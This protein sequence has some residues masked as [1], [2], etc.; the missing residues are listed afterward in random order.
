[1]EVVDR[2]IVIKERVR[3]VK[4]VEVPAQPR[5]DEWAG[6][7]IELTRQLDSGRVYDRHLPDIAVAIDEILR[8]LARRN[9]HHGGRMWPG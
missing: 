9:T 4:R 8:S 6:L 5:R 7:L 2:V 3:V 1:V